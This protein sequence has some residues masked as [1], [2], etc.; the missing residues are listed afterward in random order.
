MKCTS[1]VFLGA[2]LCLAGC[3]GSAPSTSGNPT[4]GNSGVTGNWELVLTSTGYGP[5]TYGIYLTQTGSNASG[6]VGMQ[7]AYPLCVLALGP[8]CAFPFGTIDLVLDGTVDAAG[9]IV[10]NLNSDPTY[11]GASLSITASTTS[12]T[13]NGS[14][15]ITLVTTS[16]AGKWTDHGTISGTK[17][18]LLN[19]TYAGTVSSRATGLSLGLT[20]ILRQMPGLDADGQLNVS[21]RQISPARRVSRQPQ[22][23]LRS[24]ASFLAT[25]STS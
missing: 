25:S 1:F 22:H 16:P 19:G 24:P 13:L 3:G 4:P 5:A 8:P 14:Y 9:N 2:A 15:S 20:T 23:G 10:L 21:D 7:Q 18:E 12:A 17:I 11:P 6:I